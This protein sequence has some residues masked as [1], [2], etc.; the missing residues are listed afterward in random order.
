MR[1]L[2]AVLMFISGCAVEQPLDS[3]SPRVSYWNDTNL[4]CSQWD[5]GGTE[6]VAIESKIDFCRPGKGV[7]VKIVRS[8]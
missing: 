3:W 8:L 6:S 7:F 2:A 1:T 4:S 5:H